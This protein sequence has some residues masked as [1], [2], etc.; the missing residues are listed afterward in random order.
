M[1]VKLTYTNNLNV[2]VLLRSNM[3]QSQPV[4]PGQI[5]EMTFALEDRADGVGDLILHCDPN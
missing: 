5:L 2:P 1:I 3:G 4:E